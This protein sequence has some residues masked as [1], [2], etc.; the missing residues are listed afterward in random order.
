MISQ[1]YNFVIFFPKLLI[2][3]PIQ[4]YLVFLV[5]SKCPFSS[6]Q[7]YFLEL[8]LLLLE[9]CSCRTPLLYSKQHLSLKCKKQKTKKTKK[10]VSLYSPHV[11]FHTCIL[12]LFLLIWF[13]QE[14]FR[15]VLLMYLH[16]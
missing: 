1:L 2:D 13:C 16:M 14:S 8:F 6:D 12:K 7:Y 4:L 11:I 3:F 5:R 9:S 10:A 15:T